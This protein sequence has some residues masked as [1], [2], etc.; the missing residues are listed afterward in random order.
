MSAGSSALFG[1]KP[2]AWIAATW[3]GLA[4]VCQLS[5]SPRIAL[6]AE[7][8]SRS[9]GFCKWL[10]MP[11]LPRCGPA[12]LIT[13]VFAVVPLMTK[14]AII[15]SP[16]VC[17]IPRV[18]MLKRREMLPPAIDCAVRWT[19]GAA[20]KVPLPAW[21]AA[22]VQV[23]TAVA[24]SVVP[25]VIEQ[26]LGV[27]E[28][29]VTAS[30]ELAVAESVMLVPAAMVAG[31]LNVIVCDCPT[32]KETVEGGAVAKPPVADAFAVTVQTPALTPVIVVPD[33]VHTPGVLLVSVT[34]APEFVLTGK[35]TACPGA[36]D[37]TAPKVIVVG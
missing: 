25:L 37:G 9:V 1:W 34:P 14:P 3:A 23:P 33:T 32:L 2:V 28:L 21:S 8:T 17:T 10:V 29:N 4:C 36:I 35:E 31:M 16:P 12:T 20:A 27:S 6:S 15:T 18:E 26:T 5:L 19:C 7:R 11:K 22:T 13:T 24:V 30:P